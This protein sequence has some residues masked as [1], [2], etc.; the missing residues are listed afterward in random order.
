MKN[1]DVMFCKFEIY[2]SVT[3]EADKREDKESDYSI[4]RVI[5]KLTYIIVEVK[6]SVGRRLTVDEQDKLAQPFLKA[7]Y[8]YRKEGSSLVNQT[9]CDYF[10]L[11]VKECFS[12]NTL[13]LTLLS[14]L[15]CAK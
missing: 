6:T 7:I 15:N 11:H 4:F 3:E 5:N 8:I 9:I 12:K 10:V 1:W 14:Y 2:P 13:L